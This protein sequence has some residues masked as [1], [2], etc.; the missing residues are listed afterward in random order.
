VDPG[1]P[2]GYVDG[3]SLYAY[4]QG[5]PFLYVDPTG[6]RGGFFSDLWA[7]FKEDPFAVAGGYYSEA[8]SEQVDL[9]SDA[10]GG[11]VDLAGGVIDVIQ[12]EGDT[13]V[14]GQVATN[15][16]T[17]G[18][19]ETLGSMASGAVDA[20]GGHLDRVM[21][22]DLEA[23]G[24]TFTGVGLAIMPGAGAMST[25]DK[26]GDAGKLTRLIQDVN[27]NP[28]PPKALRLNRPIG[29]SSTQNARMQDDIARLFE[30]GHYD[31]RVNQQQVNAMGDR[32]GINR[33]DL[34]STSRS[35]VRHYFECDR[36]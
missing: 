13:T 29:A 11:V 21:A 35:G 7:G 26:A 6:L 3:M 1:D 33:S 8:I 27:V 10:V 12:G 9:V 16:M 32:V 5:N 22:G 25:V 31:F 19:G 17:D 2:A 20:A 14:L 34:Q 30:E 28:Q 23:I 24:D 15:M 4:V 36:S 18:V